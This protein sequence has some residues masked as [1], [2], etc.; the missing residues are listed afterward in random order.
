VTP[1][2]FDLGD[3]A[4][5][6][7]VELPRL[8]IRPDEFFPGLEVDPDDWCMREPWF[9]ASASCL[10]YAMQAF[11][12]VT[13]ERIVLVDACIGSGKHRARPEFDQLGTGWLRALEATGVA[14]ADVSSVLFSHLHVD[15]VGWATQPDRDGWRSVFPNA[16][17]L[18]TGRELDYWTSADG[19][20]AMR[21]TGDYLADSI[22][23]LDDLGILDRV[24]EDAEVCPG[25]RLLPAFG[26]TPGNVAVQVSGSGGELLLVG[27]TVH[28]P[29]Q[30][31]RPELSTRYCVHPEQAARTRSQLLA[32]AAASGTPIVPAHF[33]LPSAGRVTPTDTGYTFEP[34]SDIVRP[35]QYRV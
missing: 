12:A 15:H 1:Y 34:A 29:V 4:V 35:G 13:S 27:D 24:A 31:H 17:H 25:V 28:H 20:A 30:L 6:P 32:R 10:V 2:W 26:H 8:L 22:R 3:V 5:V 23:P 21:R 18:V 33:A 9:D 7:I 16:R 11:L 19:A 14:A